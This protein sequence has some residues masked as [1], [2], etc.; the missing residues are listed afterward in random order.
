MITFGAARNFSSR[1]GVLLLRAGLCAATL[2]LGPWSAGHAQTPAAKA[3]AAKA[4][5]TTAARATP[6]AGAVWEKNAQE[7]VRGLIADLSKAVADS[8]LS[9]TARS[10]RLRSTLGRAMAS[11]RIGSFLLGENKAAAKPA[12]LAEYQKLVP[13]FIAAEFASRIDALVEQKLTLGAAKQ[14]NPKEVIVKTGFLRQRDQTTV[15]VD[16][17]VTMAAD[18]KIQLLDV[19]VNGV[20]PLVTQ[21]D[22][23]S[24]IVKADGFG[25]LITRLK[26][27]SGQG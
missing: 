23:F 16:W 5:A 19:Y 3:P 27:R 15:S 22:D 18:G 10:A 24:A 11:E 20:S 21:R 17:R 26:T 25:A 12:E 13:G 14:R 7:F 4:P 8:S 6:P 1:G 2:A 9:P